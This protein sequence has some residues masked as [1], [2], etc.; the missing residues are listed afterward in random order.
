MLE[1]KAAVPP[2]EEFYPGISQKISQ[3]IKRKEQSYLSHR[4][5]KHQSLETNLFNE[6]MEF[7]FQDIMLMKE[8]YKKLLTR[9]L[10]LVGTLNVSRSEGQ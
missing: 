1:K 3:E 6:N 9:R 10:S 5:K 4:V 8:M 7:F 2:D